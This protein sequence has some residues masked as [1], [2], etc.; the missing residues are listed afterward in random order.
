MQTK[1]NKK[2]TVNM[3]TKKLKPQG[4]RILKMF[5]IF[6]AF[7]WIV[8]ALAITFLLFAT[9]PETGDELY[10]RSRILQLVDDYFVIAGA[11]GLVIS[12]WLSTRYTIDF[13]GIWERV[14]NPDFNVTE[15]SNIKN[16]AGYKDELEARIVVSNWMSTHFTLDFWGLWEQIYNPNFNRMEFHTVKNE[17]GRRLVQ[18]NKVAITQMRSLVESKN[19]K[20]LK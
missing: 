11:T 3:T 18:L 13:L 1:A 15:F 7:C 2:K 12:H 17:S 6:F 20:Q 8:G 9:R 4:I 5:H 10:M 19:L 14:N 16:E